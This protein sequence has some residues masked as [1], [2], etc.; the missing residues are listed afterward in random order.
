MFAVLKEVF[1]ITRLGQVT[2]LLYLFSVTMKFNKLTY[3]KY[4]ILSNNGALLQGNSRDNIYTHSLTHTLSISWQTS[5][6][7]LL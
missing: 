2:F 7:R 1:R 4:Y 3:I 6:E 5:E